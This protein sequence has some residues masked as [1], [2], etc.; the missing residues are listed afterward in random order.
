MITL[1]V[2]GL[3]TF[4][5]V[6]LVEDKSTGKSYA[7][8]ALKKQRVVNM[9]QTKNVFSERDCMNMITHPLV[10][11]LHGTYY[12][13]NTLF[14]LLEL[15]VGGELWNLMHGENINHLKKTSLGGFKLNACKFY[16]SNVLG[17]LEAMHKL[18]IAYRDLKP[19]NLCI[20]ERGYLKIVDLGFAK[21]LKGEKL[22]NTLCG[23]PE[24]LAP[25]LVLSKGHNQAVDMWALGILIFELVTCTTPFE[26][27]NQTLMF[28][29]ISNSEEVLKK[30]TPSKMDKH[31]TSIIKKL[32][33]PQPMLRLG[34]TVGG[35]DAIWNH[36][37][38]DGFTSDLVERRALNAPYVPDINENN[39]VVN[40]S[41][42]EEE[43]DSD[44]IYIGN[45]DF[46]YWGPKV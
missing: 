8:K 10:M 40:C 39:K 16:A 30:N 18:N 31:T 7:L 24:Y 27:D 37:W 45:F 21:I 6:K 25:E 1:Q 4:G 46:R 14:M 42:E 3:G 9:H 11:K 29:N 26:D 13:A 15:C 2:L 38:F 32:L 35:V 36:K 17:G 44:S 20:D 5:A 33:T 28:G 43:D 19:E 12:D 34:S 23:T 41:E 22:T